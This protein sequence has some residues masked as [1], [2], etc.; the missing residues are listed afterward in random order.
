[1]AGSGASGLPRL[2]GEPAHERLASLVGGEEALDAELVEGDVVG[3]AE[4]GQRRE[5]REVEVVLGEL[6][7]EEGCGGRVE[8]EGAPRLRHVGIG[9]QLVEEPRRLWMATE[10]VS[11]EPLDEGP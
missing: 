6:D 9:E 10:H 7:G 11:M 8:I 2:A 1:M 4:A 3:H 5:E